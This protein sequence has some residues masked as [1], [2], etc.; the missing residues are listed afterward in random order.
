MQDAPNDDRAFD[1]HDLASW[2]GISEWKARELGKD[3]SFPSFRIGNRHR[4]WP[5]EVMAHLARPRD[6]WKQSPQSLGHKRKRD[7]DAPS[8]LRCTRR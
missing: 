6:P 2:L 3:P 7:G 1:V 4:Y 8:Q 5:S